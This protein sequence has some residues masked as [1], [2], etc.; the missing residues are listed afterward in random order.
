MAL[1]AGTSI[2]SVR[3]LA[4]DRDI[5]GRAD[6]V[7]NANDIAVLLAL[8]VVFLVS[9]LL[10]PSTDG[11]MRSVCLVAALV[12][13]G[14]LVA[15]GSRS[16][17]LALG[18]SVIALVIVQMVRLRFGLLILS[19]GLVS[20]LASLT[21]TI[22][23]DVPQRVLDIPGAIQG[24]SLN[25][26]EHFWD[27]ALAGIPSAVGTGFGTTPAFMLQAVGIPAVMHSVYL[28]LAL[29]LGLL[30]IAVWSWMFGRLLIAARR[31]PWTQ[32][33]FLMGV[34]VAVM[35]TTLTLEARRPLWV[36]IALLASV[37]IRKGWLM[38]IESPVVRG[39]VP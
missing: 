8:A 38:R 18:I 23:V 36:Y 24:G 32:E 34:V 35:A 15:T 30:G 39:P 26:R 29:E 12:H 11:R 20:F 25:A 22:G 1:L 37:A 9:Q 27:A 5:D 14:A 3:V 7:S 6:T 19:A 21:V 13:L 28:G 16:G 17:V 33:L 10:R 31:S 4:A 2:M